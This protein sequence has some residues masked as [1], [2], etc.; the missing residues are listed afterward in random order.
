MRLLK[1]S[2]LSFFVAGVVL[3]LYVLAAGAAFFSFCGFVPHRDEPETRAEI[4]LRGI[5][6]NCDRKS[7]QASA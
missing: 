1:E 2:L 7:L 6:I 3:S 4:P 5:A